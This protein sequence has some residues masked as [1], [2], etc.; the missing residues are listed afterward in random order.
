MSLP[1]PRTHS[2]HPEIVSKF[3]NQLHEKA[4]STRNRI[5]NETLFK[6][7]DSPLL[8]TDDE[9]R[10][11]NDKK[12]INDAIPAEFGDDTAAQCTE[13]GAHKTQRQRLQMVMDTC[14]LSKNKHL[15]TGWQCVAKK[16]LPRGS[17]LGFINGELK[18]MTSAQVLDGGTCIFPLESVAVR[19]A[20]G[21]GSRIAVID[22][23]EKGNVLKFMP[24]HLDCGVAQPS[25][26]VREG[27]IGRAPILYL[28]SAR[29]IA[30]GQMLCVA[31]K[32]MWRTTLYKIF[33]SGSWTPVVHTAGLRSVSPVPP[34]CPLPIEP[35]VLS[36]FIM[37]RCGHS[38]E[39]LRQFGVPKFHGFEGTDENQ[40]QA[41]VSTLLSFIE[42]HPEHISGSVRMATHPPYVNTMIGHVFGDTPVSHMQAVQQ[43][44][45]F[46]PLGKLDGKLWFVR[47]P[48]TDHK[49]LMRAH[50]LHGLSTLFGGGSELFGLYL[51][52]RSSANN[53]CRLLDATAKDA[54][55]SSNVGF[56]EI[57]QSYAPSLY[58]ITTRV[59]PSNAPLRFQHSDAAW[60]ALFKYA[61]KGV[62]G[63]CVLRGMGEHEI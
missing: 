60:H 43:I 24:D 17:V 26:C 18:F 13:Y 20:S 19:Y 33:Q 9:L 22:A 54:S 28:I 16:E 57:W 38:S 47:E 42:R 34:S 63:Q 23:R 21:D 58:L 14:E 44:N 39:L 10:L 2:L 51:D 1:T 30:P 27:W 53:L 8:A 11:F 15:I 55:I 7:I 49:F 31:R 3:V 48:C 6:P 35:R 29:D 45:A 40:R 56:I 36:G 62:R 59:I 5:F 37:K 46:Y 12:M 50:R 4:G 41:A 25:L 32:N 52:T 61:V